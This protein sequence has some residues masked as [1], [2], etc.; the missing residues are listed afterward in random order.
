MEE[1]G[2]E[3]R[4]F[5]LA[6]SDWLTPLMS[7]LRGG[8]GSSLVMGRSWWAGLSSRQRLL[9]P[10][11]SGH[12]GPAWLT[13]QPRVVRPLTVPAQASGTSLPPGQVWWAMKRCEEA[14]KR[15]EREERRRGEQRKTDKQRGKNPER[16]RLLGGLVRAEGRV[17]RTRNVVQLADPTAWPVSPSDVTRLLSRA[18]GSDATGSGDSYPPDAAVRI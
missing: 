13:H 7:T 10:R 12:L 18:P 6:E 4:G 14:E 17:S 16:K 9:C 11:S 3:R 8:T 1:G 15:E 5:G 2:R